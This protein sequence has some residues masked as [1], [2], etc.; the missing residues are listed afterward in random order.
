MKLL[1]K[2][3]STILKKFNLKINFF[4]DEDYFDFKKFIHSYSLNK[5]SIKFVQLGGNDGII[6]DPIYDLCKQFPE[7]FYGHIFEP[8]PEYFMDLKKNY[9]FSKNIQ[10][11]NLAIHNN[12]KSTVIYNFV[13]S[14]LNT[15]DTAF[16]ICNSHS[17]NCRISIW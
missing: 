13:L 3:I 5:K 6:N 7:K 10:L 2:I 17:F 11:Q 15:M 8:V 4:F 1:K 12:L 16:R 9:K 14:F